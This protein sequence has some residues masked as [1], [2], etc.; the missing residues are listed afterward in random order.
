MQVHCYLLSLPV[1][2]QYQFS[3]SDGVLS[4]SRRILHVV[5]QLFVNV[6]ISPVAVLVVH[7]HGGVFDE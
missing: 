6:A 5:V 4:S 2:K 7:G 3:V 1:L